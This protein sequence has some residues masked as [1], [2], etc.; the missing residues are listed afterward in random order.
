MIHLKEYKLITKFTAHYVLLCFVWVLFLLQSCF[1]L[2]FIK[3]H[4]FA[5]KSD[6]KYLISPYNIT[7]KS[8]I[9]VTRMKEM[10]TS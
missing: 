2:F 1:K 3:F 4:P 9:K 10:I 8:H 7:P 6:C 5:P